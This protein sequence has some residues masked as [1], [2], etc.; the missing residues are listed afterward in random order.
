MN[1]ENYTKEDWSKLD[2]WDW[3]DLLIEQPQFSEHCTTHVFTFDC[4]DSGRI[5]FIDKSKPE[6]IRIGCFSGTKE[7]AIV[8]INRDYSGDNAKNYIA[9][10]EECFG[11][12]ISK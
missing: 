10:V 12:L 9:K 6:I 3:R 4:G 2:G 7:E 1:Y 8:A 11:K 5:I